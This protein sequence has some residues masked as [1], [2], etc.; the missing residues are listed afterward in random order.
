MKH[1]RESL[2]GFL[3][4][5]KPSLREVLRDEGTRGWGPVVKTQ[6]DSRSEPIQSYTTALLHAPDGR[7]IFVCSIE[8]LADRASAQ[9][10]V[11]DLTGASASR[12]LRANR[13]SIPDFAANSECEEEELLKVGSDFNE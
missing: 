7:W 9:H 10:F 4:R 3:A 5:V 2:A 8:D 12:W 1:G 13:F 11:K 6:F